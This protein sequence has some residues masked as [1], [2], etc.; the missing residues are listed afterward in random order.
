MLAPVG[1]S[2]V[3]GRFGAPVLWA[4]CGVLG[5]AS[6]A[7]QLALGSLRRQELLSSTAR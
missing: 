1:G 7:G 4:A 5:L 2:L 6:A 3:M